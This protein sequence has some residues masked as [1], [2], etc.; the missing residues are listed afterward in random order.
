MKKTISIISSAAFL[1]TAACQQESKVATTEVSTSTVSSAPATQ[2]EAAPSATAG[3]TAVAS[4]TAMATSTVAPM[5]HEHPAG[6][7]TVKMPDSKTPLP[8]KSPAAASAAMSHDHHAMPMTASGAKYV[9]SNVSGILEASNFS[10]PAAKDAYAKAKEIP[11]R[12]EQMY[13]Y[14]HCKENPG[15]KHK[16]LLTCFQT[17]H[18]SECGI[19]MQEAVMA[20]QD[21][22]DGIP[23]EGTQKAAD[24]M[25]NNGNPAP[26][27]SH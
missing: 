21:Y 13:C 2:P 23:V 17:D 20:W 26:G 22:K 10:D 25:Y 11:D 14:C 1:L 19:C 7:A 8:A 9:V 3:T 16:S 12:L 4:E 6:D 15:L 18:A 24:L 27:H 5:T